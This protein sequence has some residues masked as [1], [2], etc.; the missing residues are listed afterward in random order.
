MRQLICFEKNSV[1]NHFRAP[2]MSKKNP[3]EKDTLKKKKIV[4]SIFRFK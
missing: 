1:R 4:N 3:K 2:F